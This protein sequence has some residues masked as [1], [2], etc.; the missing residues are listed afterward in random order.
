MEFKNIFLKSGFKNNFLANFRN[1]NYEAK[2]VEPYKNDPTSEFFGAIGFLSK[3]KFR[4]EERIIKTLFS[5]KLLFRYSPGTMRKEEEGFILDPINAFSLNRLEN[6]NNYETGS[7]STVGF[8]YKIK[9]KDKKL[10]F[11]LAQIISEKENKKMHSK[12]SMDEQLSDLTGS[13]NLQLNKNFSINYNFN[14]DQNYND[15]NYNE[16][17]TNLQY[18]SI[19]FDFNYLQENKHIGNQDYFLTK[20]KYENINNS[21]I[22]F[23][24]KRNLITDSSEFYNLS[25]EYINDC[26]R[27]GL[28]Y[29]RE[30]Y[31][32]SEIEPENSLMFKITLTPFGNLNSPSFSQ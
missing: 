29:R 20:I 10:D 19:N 15:F 28:V 2:N 18:G 6:L 5:P 3:I 31:N 13:A 8:D 22:S 17:G 14:I 1:I 24:T 27:A 26:L 32:D 9:N 30:F 16:I 4:K 11:S 7:S 23:E 12:T 21:L 25:Y